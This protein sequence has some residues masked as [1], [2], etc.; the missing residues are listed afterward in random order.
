MRTLV[1]I[2]DAQLAE[3]G[4][5]CDQAQ[6]SRSEI[7]RRAITEYIAKQSH[8]AVDAFGLWKRDENSVDG[9]EYQE[10]LRDEW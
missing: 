6:T 2:P 10:Q 5:L 1:D 3:L 4:R 8:E 9:L 7:I